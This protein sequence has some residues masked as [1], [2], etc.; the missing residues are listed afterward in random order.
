MLVLINLFYHHPDEPTHILGLLLFF[1]L[2]LIVL[3]IVLP[4]ILSIVLFLVFLLLILLLLPVTCTLSHLIPLFRIT[5]F[6][7]K[8]EQRIGLIAFL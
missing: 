4:I 5:R 1:L 6:T 3:F 2:L 7:V 8:K